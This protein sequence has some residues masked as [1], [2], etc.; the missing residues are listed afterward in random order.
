MF[1]KG[2]WNDSVIRQLFQIKLLSSDENKIKNIELATYT[3]IKCISTEQQIIATI[4]N[5]LNH[6]LIFLSNIRSNDKTAQY[7]KKKRKSI[8]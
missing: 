2:I 4:S 8:V 5:N 6:I 1:V 7:E 3:L